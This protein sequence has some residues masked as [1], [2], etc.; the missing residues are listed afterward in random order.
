MALFDTKKP[1]SY[2]V[3]REGDDVIISVNLEKYPKIPSVEDDSIVMTKTCTMLIEVKD[4]TKIVFLQK[5]GVFFFSKKY[6]E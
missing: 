1:F 6:F 5:S 3:I 4:A 2:D